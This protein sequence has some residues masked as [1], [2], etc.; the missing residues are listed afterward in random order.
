MALKAAR[1]DCSL[2]IRRSIAIARTVDPLMAFGPIAYGQLK[3]RIVPP[4]K[5]RVAAYSRAGHDADGLTAGL[6]LA[7]KSDDS[8]FI[9]VAVLAFHLV[10]RPGRQL[11]GKG[12]EWSV[13]LP[14]PEESQG[15]THVSAG[16][17]LGDAQSLRMTHFVPDDM[18]C[19][20]NPPHSQGLV[21][22]LRLQRRCSGRGRLGQRT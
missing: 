2:K 20:S 17:M 6:H 12:T 11:K 15:S 8:G 1:N 13:Y 22:H 16:L 5:I 18:N 10:A 9:E 14:V 21:D 4:V 19:K 7:G 3:E